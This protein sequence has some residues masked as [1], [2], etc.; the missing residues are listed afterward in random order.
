[1]QNNPHSLKPT[2]PYKSLLNSN[3][4]NVKSLNELNRKTYERDI[5]R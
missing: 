3:N 1:M 2:N 4:G 5:L